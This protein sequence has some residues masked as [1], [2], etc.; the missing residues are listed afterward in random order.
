MSAEL[1]EWLRRLGQIS[2]TARQVLEKI[3]RDRRWTVDDFADCIV[4]TSLVPLVV[5]DSVS[6]FEL[7]AVRRAFDADFGHHSES[8]S[9][10]QEYKDG[11]RAATGATWPPPAGDLAWGGAAHR[12]A[13]RRRAF[14][15]SAPGRYNSPYQGRL[16]ALSGPTSR[17]LSPVERS[18]SARRHRSDS[19]LFRRPYKPPL[20]SPRCSGMSPWWH[21]SP[22]SSPPL[23]RQRSR[24][25]E[26]NDIPVLD[27]SYGLQPRILLSRQTFSA[28][29]EGTR[30]GAEPW[31][32][33]YAERVSGARAIFRITKSHQYEKLSMHGDREYRVGDEYALNLEEAGPYLREKI[34][35]L[36]PGAAVRATHEHYEVGVGRNVKQDR[37]LARL[38]VVGYGDLA[39]RETMARQTFLATFEGLKPISDPLHRIYGRRQPD[40]VAIFRVVKSQ[41]YEKV[42]VYGD[43]EYLVGDEFVLNMNDAKPDIA[44]QAG[45]LL[46]GTLVQ[47]AYQ[48]DY[49]GTGSTRHPERRVMQL[50]VIRRGSG[51]RETM[52]RQTITATFQGLKPQTG[53]SNA[54]VPEAF[55]KVIKSHDCEQFLHGEREYR[56]GDWFTVNDASWAIQ[57]KLRTLALGAVVRIS[58][59]QD[60]VKDLG[61]NHHTECVIDQLSVVPHGFL[62]WGEHDM[63]ARQIFS[64]TFE[65]LRPGLDSSAGFFSAKPPPDPIAV[66][67]VTESHAYEKP[68]MNLYGAKE[69]LSGD[70]FAIG[71]N[72]TSPE[73]RAKILAMTPGALV[74]AAY[75]YDYVGTAA[76]KHPSRRLTQMKVISGLSRETTVR[77]TFTAVFQEITSVADPLPRTYP[78]RQSLLR[79]HFRVLKSIDYDKLGPYGDKELSSGEEFSFN[80]D[81]A[82]LD[83]REQVRTLTAGAEV[84]ISYRQD[85]VGTDGNLHP[86]R[87]LTHLSVLGRPMRDLL[88]RQQ[89]SATYEGISAD[90]RL[91]EHPLRPADSLAMFRVTASLGYEQFGGSGDKEMKAGDIFSFNL[92]DTTDEIQERIRSLA[93]GASATLTCEHSYISSGGMQRSER[94]VT[95]LALPTRSFREHLAKQTFAAVFE[96]VKQG[97]EPA[98]ATYAPAP[99]EPRA[100]FRVTYSYEYDKLV[101][102]GDRQYLAGDEFSF[103]L[104]D[105]S[106]QIW[107]RVQALSLGATVE[108]SYSQDYVH[109]DGSKRSERVVTHLSSG[110]NRPSVREVQA[111]QTFMAVFQHIRKGPLI[112]K[113]KDPEPHAVFNVIKSH[114][115][116]VTGTSPD[117]EYTEGSLFMLPLNGAPAEIRDK[118]MALNPGDMVQ[119]KYE[120]SDIVETTGSKRSERRVLE[121]SVEAGP[122]APVMG[123]FSKIVSQHAGSYFLQ[124]GYSTL[125]GGYIFDMKTGSVRDERSGELLG[126]FSCDHVASTPLPYPAPLGAGHKRIPCIK[127]EDSE[128]MVEIQNPANGGA[129]FVLPSQLNG[130]EYPSHSFIVDTIESYKYDNT[131][132][133]RAQLAVHPGP[134]QFVL[135]NAANDRRPHGIS[136]VSSILQE[137]RLAGFHFELVNGYLALPWLT[138]PA[139]KRQALDVFRQHLHKMHLLV[140]EDIPAC[141]LTPDKLALSRARHRVSLL[142]AS[143][144]P[145]QAYVN[146]GVDSEQE[147]FQVQISEALLFAQYFGVLKMASRRRDRAKVFLLPLGSGVFNN[148]WESIAKSI[149]LAVEL[150]EE[151]ERARLDIRVLTWSGNTAE[152]AQMSK[153]LLAHGKLHT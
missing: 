12:S 145:V 131:G 102:H 74:Q 150:L 1:L 136:A 139:K 20:T 103:N 10:W 56:N 120:H 31:M 146:K 78:P 58:F 153:F 45:V 86:Q 112:D 15:A 133:P 141:G 32:Y 119:I 75:E 137:T 52:L 88:A 113:N 128:I 143:A 122:A 94:R 142:Y 53:Y 44:A 80:L 4:R 54:A 116:V 28:T 106:P 24:S 85:F 81:D 62:G 149:A 50:M 104:N 125:S 43:R 108:I 17:S 148:P 140:M 48:H 127:I 134:G 59:H 63:L 96:G 6:P 13:V 67:R 91:R 114:D 9:L 33:S 16:G 93:P 83:I 35:A 152:S 39:S 18:T 129:Y 38:T 118:V 130:A 101:P 60:Y 65:G 121:L 34:K 64:A 107:Q 73:V 22:W 42:G 70:E 26:F 76:G 61:G 115:Y 47:I 69:Y 123:D 30:P 72:E 51:P 71:L 111:T 2:A 124:A 147:A 109:S 46:P 79:A 77:Q 21:D 87:V 92:S 151:E 90:P 68:G 117:S 84:R 66:F 135:D 7:A 110:S 97:P 41:E 8:R 36:I 14:S 3:A 5:L 27:R 40:S 100:F 95:E 25:Q 57:E 37:T 144:V 11:R 55:F 23:M 89:F 126:S 82:T 98:S 138:D 19:P 99:P 132:G 29:Y 105:V 49:V